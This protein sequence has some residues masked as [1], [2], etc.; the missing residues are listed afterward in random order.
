MRTW[1][2]RRPPAAALA[3]VHALF[4][5]LEERGR[6]SAGTLSGGEQQLLAFGRALMATPRV[7]LL[8]EPT[9]GLAPEVAERLLGAVREVAA[10][11]AAVLLVD[12]PGPALA[13]ADRG[14]VLVA[15]RVV[16][17]GTPEALLRDQ[18]GLADPLGG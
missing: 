3:R 7:L 14:V 18:D 12:R 17:V 16:A 10:D 4:P 5:V 8:D 2:G 11:G 1:S 15:G 13:T 9:T 6:Q